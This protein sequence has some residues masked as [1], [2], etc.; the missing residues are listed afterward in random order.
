M[1]L[2]FGMW[3]RALQR[4][5]KLQEKREWDALDFVTKWLIATRGTVTQLTVFAC[6]IAGLLA[7]R[8]GFFSWLPWLVMTAGLYLA[9]STENLLND[10]IDFSRG[11]DE[12]NYYRAQYGV[13][14]L[15][16]KFWTRQDWLRWF[17]GAGILAT[18]AGLFILVY[19]SFS[20]VVIG[21]FLFGA[22]MIPFYAY[23]LKYWGLGELLIFLNWGLVLI[24]GIY[25]ILAGGLTPDLPNVVL[26]GMAF[27]F[28]F[29]SFN[30]G[31][32]IDKL[33]ADK[34]KG[35][36]TLP[37]RLGEP[38]ARYVN[39]A[40]VILSYLVVIYLVFA[41][42]FFTPAPLLVFFAAPRAWRVI[43]LLSQPRPSEAPPGFALWPR[44]FST[45]QLLHIRLFGGLYI[46]GMFADH[47]L[48]QWMPAFWH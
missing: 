1:S 29:G 8:D 15:V 21:L 22:V 41:V 36:R 23:P 5:I 18:L 47:L 39:I 42:R 4:P 30:W 12:D 37:V 17:L 26:A 24:P 14:P 43:R 45:P 35:V 32:H 19:T 38:A 7:W 2:D 44:W 34:S 46:L 10:Y 25:T 13:H 16:H 31:K 33:Y 48:R 28:G 11:I 20:P 40:T 6:V 3:W 27:G 9:H